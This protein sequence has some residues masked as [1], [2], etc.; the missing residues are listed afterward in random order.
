M[1]KTAEKRYWKSYET[2]DLSPESLAAQDI[3]VGDVPVEQLLA[4]GVTNGLQSNRRDFLK[5]FGFSIGAATLAACNKTSVKYALPYVNN[6]TD[7]TPG[8]ANFYASTL[9]DGQ[10]ATS[11]LIK[12]REGRPIKIEGNHQSPFSTGG[13]NARGQAI[14]LSLYDGARLKD[15]TKK[16]APTTW[17]KADAEIT[18]ALAAIAREGKEISIVTPTVISPSTLAAIAAFKAKYPTAKH[19]NYDAVSASAILEANAKT[20]G[21]AFIPNY[22]FDNA[23]SIVSINADFLGTWLA[24]TR[25]TRQYANTRRLGTNQ[26]GDVKKT[27][28]RHTQFESVLSITGSN[29]DY[30]I[31][32]RPSQEGAVALALYNAVAEKAGAPAYNA[33]K[34]EMA[35]NA[36]SMA[37]NDLW[38][39]RGK[40]LV[41]SGSQDVHVQVLVNAMNHLLESYGSTID[42]ATPLLTH[43]GMDGEM[44]ALVAGL[45]E[46]RVGAVIFYGSNPI[47]THPEAA[48]LEAALKKAT[49]RISLTDRADETAQQADY[50]LPDHHTL[51]AW[52]DVQPLA[53]H[54]GIAQPTINPLYNTRHAQESFLRWSGDKRDY[55]TFVKANWEKNIY[56]RFGKAAFEA[57]WNQTLHD[58]FATAA[59]DDKGKQ[60][61]R[62]KDAAAA[63][64]TAA[65]AILQ[66]PAV[67]GMEV[68]LYQKIA[69]G[70]GSMANSPWLQELPDPISKAT[71]DNYLLVNKLDAEEKSLKMGAVAKITVGKNTIELP[72]YIAP[73]QARGTVGIALGYG[74][75]HAGK[76]GNGVGKN[77]Y[78]LASTLGGH[79]VWS[80]S[81]ASLESTGATHDFALT[82]THQTIMGRDIVRETTVSEYQKD[83]YSANTE[84]YELLK[85]KKGDF[86]TLWE[87]HEKNGHY[88]AMAID[89]NACT[90][91][92][93][94]V[95]SCQAENNIPVVGKDEVRRSRE[96]HWIRIDR[97]FSSSGTDLKSMENSDE[98]PDVVFQPMLCQHCDNA[99]CET[100]CPVL[101]TTHSSEGINQ[102]T[103]NR[104]IGTRYC[105]NNCPYKV[106]R[107]N[108]FDYANQDGIKMSEGRFSYNPAQEGELGRLVLNPD[109][110]VRARGVMEKCTFCVQRLQAAKLEAKKEG[111]PLRDG[112]ANTACAQ[113]CPAGAIV[114]GDLNDPTSAISKLYNTERS[115]HVLAEVKT[116]PHISYMTKVRNR[117]AAAAKPEQAEK[118]HA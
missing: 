73:G 37:A 54:Y 105:A 97:Y 69:I 66:A 86:I 85:D 42:T 117:D 16:D 45:N 84:K 74:R 59:P 18:D 47:Y 107:F 5:F 63:T 79:I 50:V 11:V 29:A 23:E 70:N 14:V 98:Y 44:A 61:G 53:G 109:V 92:G 80:N 25:Y 24:S 88:W 33:P 65:N 96:M 43:Q 78:P 110:T 89:L 48:A 106:R 4:E 116:L 83:P 19:I 6:P 113:S 32:M 99:P 8:I 17:E 81:G 104:C 93:A 71:W 12:T 39:K 118:A 58:G 77:A 75:T 49:L 90:G 3:F 10:E 35:G 46:G 60:M 27:M 26:H 67:Q 72:V 28:S 22:R 13:V 100:V 15:P 68:V 101:A 36:I 38:A 108:W 95:V 40:A 112:E 20:F 55:Y 87:K 9:Y 102:M 7:L 82:Q 64:G 31:P 114:F 21:K 57:F 91:C 2:K 76:A 94:C 41:V 52:G 51:E 30:R 103:Y 1:E 111:R 34:L 115:Y 56:P 62:A